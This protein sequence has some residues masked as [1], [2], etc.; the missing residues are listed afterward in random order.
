MRPD[1]VHE[2]HGLTQGRL[3][4]V[5]DCDAHAVLYM[6]LSLCSEVHYMLSALVGG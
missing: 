5:W 6:L 1:L 2:D 3:V 4:M